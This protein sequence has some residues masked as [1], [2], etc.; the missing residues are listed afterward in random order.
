[1]NDFDRD[2]FWYAFFTWFLA[3]IYAVEFVWAV[4]SDS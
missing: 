4:M 1:M 2:M 3:A